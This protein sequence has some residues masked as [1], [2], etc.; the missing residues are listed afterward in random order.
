VLS[1]TTSGSRQL[2]KSLKKSGH[3]I[4]FW[5]LTVSQVLDELNYEYISFATE[6]KMAQESLKYSIYCLIAMILTRPKPVQTQ[7]LFVLS[8][9]G[10]VHGCQAKALTCVELYATATPNR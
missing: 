5:S 10:L 8:G 4:C 6:K 3:G 9:P 1:R 7:T 2:Q